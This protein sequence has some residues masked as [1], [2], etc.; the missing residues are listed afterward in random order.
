MGCR[1]LALQKK[2]NS[3]IVLYVNNIW[4]GKGGQ[5]AD[6]LIVDRAG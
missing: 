1:L 3:S 4:N 5:R 6:I 2:G